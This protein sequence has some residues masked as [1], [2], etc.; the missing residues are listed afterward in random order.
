MKHDPKRLAKFHKYFGMGGIDG[1]NRSSKLLTLNPDLL[2]ADPAFRKWLAAEID[3]SVSMATNLIVY[4]D[5]DGSKKL[6]EVA[7]E[8][9]SEKWE[10]PSQSDACL[11]ASL[12]KSIL[13][14]SPGCWS[15]QWLRVMAVF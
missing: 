10:L 14:L 15:R 3:W 6:G 11:T 9:L 1:F 5:D 7:H 12:I 8:M 13:K 4:A 2:L